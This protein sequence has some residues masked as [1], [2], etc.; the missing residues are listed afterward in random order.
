M[1]S[2]GRQRVFFMLS[3]MTCFL[4]HCPGMTDGFAMRRTGSN[5]QRDYWLG[6]F[7]L[8]VS[9][10]LQFFMTADF[11]KQH[12]FFGLKVTFEHFQDFDKPCAFDRVATC[13]NDGGLPELMLCHG[14]ADFIHECAAA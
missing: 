9:C 3:R 11:A 5:Y 7:I 13:T 12:D 10:S 2:G 4:N 8:D 14:I 1:R 6:H